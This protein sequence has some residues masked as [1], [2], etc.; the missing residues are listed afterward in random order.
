LSLF[1]LLSCFGFLLLP[2]LYYSTHGRSSPSAD[3]EMY[4]D[5]ELTYGASCVKQERIGW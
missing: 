1:L 3:L 5:R 4:G 2:G